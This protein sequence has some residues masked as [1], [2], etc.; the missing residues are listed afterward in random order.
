MFPLMQNTFFSFTSN[1]NNTKIILNQPFLSFLPLK[2]VF[3][4]RAIKS[5]TYTTITCVETDH[6]LWLRKNLRH[7]LSLFSSKLYLVLVFLH[8]LL[9]QVLSVRRCIWCSVYD[10]PILWLMHFVWGLSGHLLPVLLLSFLVALRRKSVRS[11]AVQCA[12]ESRI[13][14]Y[15]VVYSLTLPSIMQKEHQSFISFQVADTYTVWS[16]VQWISGL[17]V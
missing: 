2:F 12:E 1:R 17:E 14:P 13:L 8:H 15:I 11:T 3:G 7:R 4:Q 9:S 16:Y 5:V 6:E 10:F